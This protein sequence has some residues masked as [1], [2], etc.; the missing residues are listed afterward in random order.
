MQTIRPEIEQQWYREAMHFK[1]CGFKGI[2]R[3]TELKMGDVF[4]V[5]DQYAY[6][7]LKSNIQSA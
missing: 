2:N 4:R 5:S 1:I 3:Y 7:D 6:V